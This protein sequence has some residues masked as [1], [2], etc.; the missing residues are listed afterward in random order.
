MK[1]ANINKVKLIALFLFCGV[2]LTSCKSSLRCELTNTTAFTIKVSTIDEKTKYRIEFGE[3]QPG[4]SLTITDWGWNSL[5]LQHGTTINSYIQQLPP[6]ECL[7]YRGWGPWI[8]PMFQAG[9]LSD[10]TL[11]LDTRCANQNSEFPITPSGV[12]GITTQ[13]RGLPWKH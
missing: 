3:I 9:I 8:V 12:K 1:I 11:V 5:E 13:S 2:V 6:H 4:E 10:D 7:K